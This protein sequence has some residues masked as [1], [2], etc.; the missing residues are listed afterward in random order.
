MAKIVSD[1]FLPIGVT[2]AAAM[3]ALGSTPLRAGCC[4]A[5]T[6]P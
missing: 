3:D 5:R 6:S 4:E 2:V 1:E